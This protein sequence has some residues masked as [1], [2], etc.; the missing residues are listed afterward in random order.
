MERTLSVGCY[1]LISLGS[2][3]VEGRSVC[4]SLKSGVF[5]EGGG[6]ATIQNNTIT[7]IQDSVFNGGQE[8]TAIRVGRSAASGTPTT[9]TAVI[10]SNIISTYQKDGI[11]V[12]NV[13]SSATITSNIVTGVGPTNVVAQNGIEVSDG[14]TGTVTSNIVTGNVYTGTANFFAAGILLYQPGSGV[15]VTN[16]AMDN[17][18]KFTSYALTNDV[19][20]FVLDADLPVI[21]NNDIVGSTFYGIALDTAGGAGDRGATV[22]NN[23]LNYNNVDGLSL[24]SVGDFVSGGTTTHTKIANDNMTNNKANGITLFFSVVNVTI[25]QCNGTNNGGDGIL[26]VDSTSTGNNINNCNFTG[27]TGID[28]VDNSHGSGTA[29]TANTWSQNTIGTKSPSGLH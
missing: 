24:A 1:D 6:S 7:N 9:G 3:F 28:A 23:D 22:S 15:K 29:S 19:G 8:G 27:N 25:T 4:P 18:G 11:D 13:G 12:T 26:V 17:N 21:T 2:V 16:N 5:V 20:I 10:S 14:A